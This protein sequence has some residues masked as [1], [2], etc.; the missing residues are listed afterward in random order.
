MAMEYGGNFTVNSIF[1][2]KLT[3]S[4]RRPEP[5]SEPKA[6]KKYAKEKYIAQPVV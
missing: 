5:N 2:A 6:R 3:K 1:E 4:D